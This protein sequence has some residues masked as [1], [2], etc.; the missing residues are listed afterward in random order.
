MGLNYALCFLMHCA[1]PCLPV[2]WLVTRQRC[3]D[4]CDFEKLHCLGVVFFIISIIVPSIV[5]S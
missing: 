3:I 4:L 5:R 2:T 1:T